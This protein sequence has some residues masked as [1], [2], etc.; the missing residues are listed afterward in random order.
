MKTFIQYRNCATLFL[1]L[2]CV[3]LMSLLF[4][5]SCGIPAYIPV[6]TPSSPSPA[7]VPTPIPTP[8]P[9]PTPTSTPASTPEKSPPITVALDYFG[10]RNTHYLAQVGGDPLA[11]I[12]LIVVV[13]DETGTLAVWPPQNV[14]NLTFDMDYF[15]IEALKERINP[16]VIFNG[17][18]TGTL[19]I[20]VAA[21]NVNKGIITRSQIDI[22]S[23]LLGFPDLNKLKDAV[24]DRELVGYYWQTWS[25]LSN[26]GAGECYNERG[27]GNLRVWLRIGADQM[28]EPV[29]QPA[30]KPD[31]RIKFSLP[32]GV[33]TRT[34]WE[35]Y[36]SDFTFAL[37]NNES[38]E[39]PVYWRLE[40]NSSPGTEINYYVYP[41]E[42][43]VSVPANGTT[44]VP[45]KYWFTTPGNYQWK[46]V[47]E[48]PKGNLVDSLEE[49]L[50]ISP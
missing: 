42:G 8:I 41:T 28:P 6:P 32:T 3:L 30:L 37:R 1:T 44:T 14:Q 24:P 49:M 12:Q 23:K 5:V 27:D 34:Q 40:S 50:T 17:S 2:F 15:Q 43:K 45:L 10:V 18:V 25:V 13:S 39:F 22:L 47:V 4:S 11:K 35:Y 7:T 33:R 16:P 48:C 9:T 19:V 36:A 46:Y 20:Y 21:Y 29:Q 38:F 26:W 31:V